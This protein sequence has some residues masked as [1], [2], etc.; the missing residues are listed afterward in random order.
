MAVMGYSAMNSDENALVEDDEVQRI[1]KERGLRGVDVIFG[2]LGKFKYSSC[3]LS[4][5]LLPNGCT[6]LVAK[7]IIAVTL[8]LNESN[9]SKHIDGF[10]K[11]S[12][13]LTAE[14]IVALDGIAAKEGK[15]QRVVMPPW[16]K[17]V[18]LYFTG[19]ASR[20]RVDDGSCSTLSVFI[21]TSQALTSAS[22]IGRRSPGEA[23]R[24]ILS[25]AFWLKLFLDC[26]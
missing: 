23:T 4:R 6:F 19:I 8:S 14:D 18:C 26:L 12:K 16:G 1:A 9:I 5:F 11:A 13:I 10:I 7:D 3:F 22:T 2:W 15:Q 20:T 21:S 24:V 17:H 25:A